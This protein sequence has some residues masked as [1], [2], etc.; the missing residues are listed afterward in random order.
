MLADS[1]LNLEFFQA[2]SISK[3]FLVY[4][5][6]IGEIL[7]FCAPPFYRFLRLRRRETTSHFTP[8]FM[9]KEISNCAGR[10]ST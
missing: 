4:V 10:T 3:Y 7:I 8:N 9:L 5:Y 6:L 2:K 1:C